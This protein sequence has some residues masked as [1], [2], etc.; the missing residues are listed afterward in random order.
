MRRKWVY[1]CLRMVSSFALFLTMLNVNSLC[2]ST[3]HQPRVPECANR[4]KKL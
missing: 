1:T 3:G 2:M 4:F